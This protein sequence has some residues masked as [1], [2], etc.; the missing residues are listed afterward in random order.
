MSPRKK[1]GKGNGVQECHK[2]ATLEM[3]TDFDWLVDNF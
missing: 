3:V 1:D 2:E